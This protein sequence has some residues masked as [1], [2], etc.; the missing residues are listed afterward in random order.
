MTVVDRC[1]CHDVPLSVVRQR[2]VA[3]RALGV[4]DE[5]EILH[6]ISEELGCGTSCGM[7]RPYV[8]LTLRT[9][10]AAFDYRDPEVARVLA[11]QERTL[12]HI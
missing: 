3:L 5:R 10:N 6:T 2:A 12:D 9:A 11:E 7:C 4:T 8:T 1:I